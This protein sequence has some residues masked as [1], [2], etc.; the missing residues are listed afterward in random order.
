MKDMTSGNNSLFAIGENRN[1]VF[2]FENAP[3]FSRSLIRVPLD[4]SIPI[5]RITKVKAQTHNSYFG[6][7]EENPNEEYEIIKCDG[8]PNYLTDLVCNKGHG[9]CVETN[10]C[11]FV[12]FF[13]ILF[14]V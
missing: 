8:Y 9:T 3:E 11:K 7:W 1:N 4:P 2:G 14:F 13:L 5:N 12:N 10:K 6:V